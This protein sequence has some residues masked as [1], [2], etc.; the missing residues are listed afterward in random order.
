[1]VEHIDLLRESSEGRCDLAGM[2]YHMLREAIDVG[3]LGDVPRLIAEI[4]QAEDWKRWRWIGNDFTATSIEEYFSK[5]PPNGLGVTIDLVERL[6]ADNPK[7]LEQ[8]NRARRGEKATALEYQDEQL[9]RPAHRPKGSKT[10]PPPAK[11]LIELANRESVDTEKS[12]S[13]V[14]RKPRPDGTSAAA[15]HRRLAKDRPD[16]HTRVLAGE[17]TPHAGMIEAGFRKKRPK[18]TPLDKIKKLLPKLTDDERDEL[19]Q[20]LDDEA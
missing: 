6:L 9:R 1:M 4:V 3:R 15:F 10:K 12:I 8:F 18:R 17:L 20:L 16:I 13:T 11:D 2:R 19:R 14:Y 5:P 7:V